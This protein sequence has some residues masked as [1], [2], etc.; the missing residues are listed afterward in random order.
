MRGREARSSRTGSNG[1][2]PRA[3]ELL[4]IELRPIQLLLHP[5]RQ[6]L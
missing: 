1:S 5:T 2:P 3:D 6:E 4:P